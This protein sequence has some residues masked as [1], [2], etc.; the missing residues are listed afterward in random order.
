MSRIPITV[1]C[2]AVLFAT[3]PI[4][5]DEPPTQAEVQQ[6]VA[7]YLLESS[8]QSLAETIETIWVN[9]G[10]SNVNR[11]VGEGEVVAEQISRKLT[12][13]A[14]NNMISWELNGF[15]NPTPTEVSNVADVVINANEGIL[16]NYAQSL[17]DAF[18][19]RESQRYDVFSTP[20]GL[21]MPVDELLYRAGHNHQ[22]SLDGI[23][24]PFT[25]S[26]CITL[27][28][29]CFHKCLFQDAVAIA[30]HGLRFGPNSTLLFIR[31]ASELGQGDKTAA[32]STIKTLRAT[33]GDLKQNDVNVISG[34]IKVRFLIALRDQSVP[35][36]QALTQR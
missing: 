32:L 9:N 2:L 8:Q 13:D 21:S 16:G 7:K 34:P 5:A 26:R 3:N 10:G 15:R 11:V 33:A 18:S 27:A 24:F 6:N 25:Q 4:H 12:V 19:I 28:A 22:H 35:S 36:N 30:Q 17:K 29:F 1:T 31:G 23:P 14:P 20:V